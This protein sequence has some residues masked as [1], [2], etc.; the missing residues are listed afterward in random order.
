[1]THFKI[2]RVDSI[3]STGP[4]V[5]PGVSVTIPKGTVEALARM[6]LVSQLTAHGFSLTADGVATLQALSLIDVM[7]RRYT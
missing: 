5:T 7:T 1:M 4:F 2:E 6:G 3:E